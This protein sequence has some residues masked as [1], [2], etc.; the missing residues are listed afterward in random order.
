VL[1]RIFQQGSEHQRRFHVLDHVRG[2]VESFDED[3]DVSVRADLLQWLANMI[4]HAR[5]TTPHPMGGRILAW[6]LRKFWRRTSAR[7]AGLFTGKIMLTVSA[8][9]GIVVFAGSVISSF[10]VISSL[11][12]RKK[13]VLVREFEETPLS[14]QSTP[15]VVKFINT[16]TPSEHQIKPIV[17]EF[18]IQG[19]PSRNEWKFRTDDGEMTFYYVNLETVSCTCKEFISHRQKHNVK[20]IGRLCKH[21]A[22]AYKKAGIWP[23][24]EDV[25]TVLLENGP[26]SGG[27]WNYHNVY[28]VHLR[29]GEKVYFGTKNDREWVDVYTRKR[30][31]GEK[32]GSFTGAYSKFGFDRGARRWSYG[33]GPPAAKE[34][35]EIIDLIP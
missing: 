13:M 6:L 34:I 14:P 16:R 27:A 1:P 11:Y 20:G 22:R 33:D 8:L 7:S 30:K 29:S 23:E 32:A 3:G 5:R 2:L 25:V 31:R 28:A 18:Q 21:L 26:F 10:S 17:V 19:T 15:K 24:Q 35:R 9:F 12:Q 4:G